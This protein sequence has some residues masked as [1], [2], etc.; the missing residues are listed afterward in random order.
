MAT[1][2][3]I[4]QYQGLDLP[5]AGTYALDPS[6]TSVEF[7]AR[8]LMISKVRGVFT[9]VSGEIHVDEVPERSSAEVAIAAASV[10]SGDDRRDAHLRSP[11]FFD[12]ER[13]PQITFRSTNVE[14]AG[15]EW[16]LHGDLTVRDVTRPVVLHVEFEG[17]TATPWGEDRIGFSAWT[18]LDREDFGLTWNQTLETGGVLVGK[19]VRIELGVEAVRQ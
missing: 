9:D 3:A 14:A 4:R 13:F 15:D 8:H 19:K 18:E 6:H 10:Q 16:L 17:A 11:D 12:V 2:A 5:E 1:T 7:I